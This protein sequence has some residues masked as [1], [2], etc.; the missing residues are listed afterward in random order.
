MG[1]TEER[2][3]EMPSRTVRPRANCVL[4]HRPPRLPGMRPPREPAG[5]PGLAAG[6]TRPPAPRPGLMQGGA[7]RGPGRGVS[8]VT[9]AHT[10]A[11]GRG[12]N[13]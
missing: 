12:T 2:S 4:D 11:G 1:G 8:D 13:H 9:P 3:P 10:S 7:A 5:R 6:P